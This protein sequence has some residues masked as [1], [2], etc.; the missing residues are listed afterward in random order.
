MPLEPEPAR[1]KVC[2]RR[3]DPSDHG[4]PLWCDRLCGDAYAEIRRVR[5][6]TAPK[7]ALDA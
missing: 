5:V 7:G 1:C 6:A 3:L 2:G 4:Y